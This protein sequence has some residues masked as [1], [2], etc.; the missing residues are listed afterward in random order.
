MTVALIDKRSSHRICLWM[1]VIAAFLK[2]IG[3]ANFLKENF[4]LLDFLNG[5][6]ENSHTAWLPF[7]NCHLVSMLLLFV[8]CKRL[9]FLLVVEEVFLKIKRA[10]TGSHGQRKVVELQ[11]TKDN[12]AKIWR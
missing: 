1:K 11:R 8:G 3:R 6:K 7:A 10:A 2:R 4:S 12:I 9:E 5:C